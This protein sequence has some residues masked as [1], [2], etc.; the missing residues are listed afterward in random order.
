MADKKTLKEDIAINKDFD[1]LTRSYQEHAVGQINFARFSVLYSR[2][3]S[4]DLA[5]IFENVRYSYK[6]LDVQ[7]G[8]KKVIKKNKRDVWILISSNNKLYGGIVMDSF[9]LFRERIKTANLA[10][11]DL[12]IIGKQGKIFMDDLNLKIPYEYFELPDTNVTVDYLKK[13]SEKLIFYENVYV[14]YGKFN[15]LVSQTAVQVAISGEMSID[16]PKTPTT[17]HRTKFLFEPSIEEILSFFENQILQL[18]LNQTV[19]EAQLARFASRINAMEAAQINIKKQ[20][21]MLTREEKRYKIIDMNKK[22]SE[23]LAGR[24]LWNRK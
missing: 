9:N 10:K 1:L 12:I 18:L 2:E 22:Q 23:L 14:F 11:I 15:N 8:I 7:K 13:I 3:F 5:E 24:R 19:Q 6:S 16:D 20:L 21:S 17:H 4:K